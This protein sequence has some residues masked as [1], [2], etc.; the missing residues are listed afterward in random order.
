MS[1][2]PSEFSQET[3]DA[4]CER[5]ADGQSL[6]SICLA[7]DM[8][9]KT[10]VFKWLAARPDFADQYARAR[11]E[12]AETLADEI[13]SIADDGTN[14]FTTKVSGD[15]STSQSVNAEHI[16]RSRLRVEARKWVASKLKPK[17]YGDK[18]E[19]TLVGADGGPIA[20]EHSGAIA[21]CSEAERAVIRQMVER[22]AKP[23]A[24]VE[25]EPA[26]DD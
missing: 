3:A 13:I 5:L 10:T 16:Q 6:R 26:G 20:I 17:K 7:D 4:I 11:E 8:P 23:A 24:W 12:Q 25:A 1:G 2:R 14:D 19:Q 9:S 22:R 18:V 21:E 15:G